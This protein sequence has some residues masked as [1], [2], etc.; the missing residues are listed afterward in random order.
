M[1]TPFLERFNLVDCLHDY[2]YAVTIHGD[3]VL[4]HNNW[5]IS[6]NWLQ[7]YKYAS[8]FGPLFARLTFHIGSLL[9]HQHS[10]SQINGAGS[11]ENPNCMLGNTR[12]SNRTQCN[13]SN[14]Y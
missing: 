8:R 12:R 1:L 11:E 14:D 3:D 13:A 6:E 5:E 10:I 9:I 7:R 4:A 2:R